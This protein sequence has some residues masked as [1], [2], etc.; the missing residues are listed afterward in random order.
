MSASNTFSLLCLLITGGIATLGIFSRHFDDSL[1]QRVGLA[2]IAIACLLRVP[3]KLAATAPEMPPVILFAQ[4]GLTVYAVGT[5]LKMR[6]AMRRN[7]RRQ[8]HRRVTD[9]EALLRSGQK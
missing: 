5:L 7:S 6:S 4:F 9:N 1:L 3:D 8:W 2:C